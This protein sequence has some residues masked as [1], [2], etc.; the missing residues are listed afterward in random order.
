[1]SLRKIFIYATN[2]FCSINN[3]RVIPSEMCPFFET[4]SSA[5]KGGRRRPAGQTLRCSVT[6]N[7]PLHPER[8]S[9]WRPVLGPTGTDPHRSQGVR[10]HSLSPNGTGLPLGSTTPVTSC[11]DG[12]CHLF[13]RDHRTPPLRSGTRRGPRLYMSAKDTEDVRFGTPV[14]SLSPLAD[15]RGGGVG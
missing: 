9:G 5:P 2:C 4:I 14:L 12:G 13:R 1:M 11:L 6:R 3:F 15:S 7:S 8:P 10:S